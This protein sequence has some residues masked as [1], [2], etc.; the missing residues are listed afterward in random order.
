PFIYVYTSVNGQQAT[1]NRQWSTGKRQKAKVNS[2]QAMVNRQ[3]A[4]G[5]RQEYIVRSL[6]SEFGVSGQRSFSDTESRHGCLV[7]SSR[8]CDFSVRLFF[9][10][11]FAAQKRVPPLQMPNFAT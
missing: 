7:P 2:Q 5:N 10:S 8:Q 4:I 9:L 1:V 3:Q 11:L 6:R